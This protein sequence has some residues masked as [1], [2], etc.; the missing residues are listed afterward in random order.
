[1]IYSVIWK[2]SSQSSTGIHIF[3]DSPSC[4]F[5]TITVGKCGLDQ[6][7]ETL[8]LQAKKFALNYEQPRKVKSKRVR[9]TK[10]RFKIGV[11]NYA[12][13]LLPWS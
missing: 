13:W 7:T 2:G 10:D 4:V 8:D 6:L 1:M 11:D 9:E 5:S 3:I 12:E